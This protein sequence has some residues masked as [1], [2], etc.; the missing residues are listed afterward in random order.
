MKKKMIIFVILLMVLFITKVSAYNTYKIGDYVFFDPISEKTCDESNYWTIYNQYTTCYR[1]FT[2]NNSDTANDRTINIILDHDIGI[3]KY[4]EYQAIL[5]N[6][7]KN[8]MRYTGQIDIIDEETVVKVMKLGDK[9]PTLAE[10]SINSGA[11]FNPFLT[12]SLFYQNNEITNNLGFW[13]KDTY[14]DNENYAYTI[15]EYGNNRLV[16]VTNVR[17]IRPVL[18]IEKSLLKSQNSI[19][20]LS[21]DLTLVNK[22]AYNNSKHN[23]NGIYGGINNDDKKV[24]YNRL[25]S[26]T[27]TSDKLVFASS[28]NLNPNYGVI[29][30]YIGTDY[31]TLNNDTYVKIGHGNGIT[32]NKRTDEIVIIGANYEEILIYDNKTMRLKQSIRP[33]YDTKIKFTQI[34]YDDIN[35]LYIAGGG[36]KIFILDKNFKVKYSFDNI[37]M[38]VYQDIEYKNGYIYFTSANVGGSNNENSTCNTSQLYC[39]DKEQSNYIYVYNAK[40]NSDGTPTVDFGKLVKRIKI[41]QGIGEIES[42]SFKDNDVYIG[43]SAHEFDPQNPYHFYKISYSKISND[44]LDITVNTKKEENSITYIFTSLSELKELEGF[45]L[46]LDKKTLSTKLT[47]TTNKT[48]QICDIY[49]NCIEQKLRFEDQLISQKSSLNQNK[50]HHISTIILI[51]SLIILILVFITILLWRKKYR[52]IFYL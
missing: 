29:F 1:F 22:Y 7:T 3:G 12:N 49:N 16:S 50:N 39:L 35:D 43:Y 15:T 9:R 51:I 47:A 46:S 17:G 23:N 34:A 2:L 44:K 24:T 27:L 41:G 18:E 11:T 21:K 6:N 52:K 33:I 26:F 37:S 42:I 28:N 19:V 14:E 8:W 48:I 32:Y 10:I 31:K 4:S 25:Q 20:D 40:L 30:S 5:T 45:E 38:Y 36:K 13:T